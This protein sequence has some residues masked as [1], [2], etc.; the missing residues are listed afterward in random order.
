MCFLKDDARQFFAMASAPGEDGKLSYELGMI[1]KRL[2]A[3]SG[4]QA[5][6][7]RSRSVQGVG[8]VCESTQ[9]KKQIR[10]KG[11]RFSSKIHHSETQMKRKKSGAVLLYSD[12]FSLNIFKN[13][14]SPKFWFRIQIQC[15]VF[16][17]TTLATCTYS[18]SFIVDRTSLTSSLKTITDFHI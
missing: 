8:G 1:M 12:L 18:L 3:D 9:L 11:V 13:I 4:V 16:G 2:W 10:E 6:F 5:C 7:H 17:F 14:F 15:T